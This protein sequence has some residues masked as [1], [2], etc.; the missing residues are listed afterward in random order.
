VLRVRRA[1][2][3][4]TF[5]AAVV[6]LALGVAVLVPPA[7]QHVSARDADSR[8]VRGSLHV[9]TNR[10][11]GTGTVDDVAEAARRAGL[12]FVILTDHGDGTRVPAPPVYR[13]GV[14]VI[15]AVEISTTGGHYV[16]LGLGRAPYRLA[17]EPRDVVDDVTRLGG[18]GIVAHPDSPKEELRWRDW[19]LPFEG[20]EWL[21]ADSEW[22]NE[23]TI[24]VARALVTYWLRGPETITAGF[25]RPDTPFAEWDALSQYRRVIGVAGHDAHARIGLRGNWEPGDRDVSLALP[26]YETAFRAFSL[27]ARLAVSPTGDASRDATMLLDALRAGHLYTV[28]DALASPPA[29]R[30]LARSGTRVAEAGDDLPVADAAVLEADVAP[31]PGVS[32]VLRRNGRVVAASDSGHLRFD[33]APSRAG[34]VYR[35]EAKLP[36]APGSPPVPW[37]VSNPIFIGPALPRVRATITLAAAKE[38]EVVFNGRDARA[39]HVEQDPTSWAS[40]SKERAFDP[41]VEPRKEGEPATTLALGYRLSAGVPAGQYAALVVGVGQG[42]LDRFT[43]VRFRASADALMRVS[44][45]LRAPATGARWLRSVVVDREAGV[46]YVTFAEMAAVDAAPIPIPLRA[47]DSILF[48]VDTTNTPPG[49]QGTL[50]LDDVR[51]ERADPQVRTVSS[52]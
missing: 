51:L 46:R 30:F 36:D 18:F 32:L 16:A 24:G 4:L 40:V 7:T 21:N 17:G 15:D 28:V 26:G 22:R 11:D 8:T 23:G 41:A 19:S 52:K 49:R 13:A 9:H 47:V 1:R 33:H 6:A 25:D 45:Q 2:A 5:A 44:V 42:R 3:L 31:V 37:I 35:I 39:W 20:I 27:R 10:S 12:Q 43:R 50:W 38:S 14:L 34:T 48:V 29:F